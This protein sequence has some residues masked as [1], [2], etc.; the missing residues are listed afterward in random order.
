V[1]HPVSFGPGA[2]IFA[3]CIF[4]VL[5]IDFGLRVGYPNNTFGAF[6][7]D[8]FGRSSSWNGQHLLLKKF[9]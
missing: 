9:A 5:T 4:T 1:G 2:Q 3:V 6:G 7:S 8:D